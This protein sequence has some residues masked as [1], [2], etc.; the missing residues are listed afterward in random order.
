MRFGVSSLAAALFLSVAMNANA[1]TINF[2]TDPFA[3]TDALITPGRQIIGNELFVPVLDIAN[4]VLSFDAG[5]FGI[6]AISFANDVIANIPATGVNTIVLRT[7]DNDGDPATPFGAGSAANLIADQITSP[8]AGFFVYFNSGLDLARLVYSTD[9]SDN[10]ADLKILARFLN[11]S[12]QPGRD[13]MATFTEANFAITQVPEPTSLVLLAIS[14][15][16]VG[17]RSARRRRRRV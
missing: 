14:G 5:V 1:D 11:L 3:G 9:L 13:A 4:D 8:G 12:G 16:W 6:N 2:A 7:F 15:V 10:T 17:H